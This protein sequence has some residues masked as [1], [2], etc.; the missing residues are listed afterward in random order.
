MRRNHYTSIACAKNANGVTAA[1]GF[2]QRLP[3][4]AKMKAKVSNSEVSAMSKMFLH[5]KRCSLIAAVCIFACA[6]TSCI[7]STFNLASESRLPRGMAIPPGLTR[8]DVF[9]TLDY[10]GISGAKFTMRDKKG[11]KLATV[12]GKTKGDPIDLGPYPPGPG[13][14]LVV[15]NGVT[16]IIED[17]PYRDNANMVQ[18]GHIVALFNVVD[19][20]ALRKELL[21]RRGLH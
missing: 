6:T 12:N 2:N 4:T 1:I 5:I 20:P 9:V 15:I 3:C 21:A 19:N 18:N 13:Y 17:I 14:Q 11:K 10:I 7:E 8:A 16:E